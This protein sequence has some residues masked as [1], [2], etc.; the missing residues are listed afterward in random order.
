MKAWAA[1]T[2]NDEGRTQKHKGE[3]RAGDGEKEEADVNKD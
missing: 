3:S 1:S 2:R